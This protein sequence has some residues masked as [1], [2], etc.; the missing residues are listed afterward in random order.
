MIEV[1][2]YAINARTWSVAK[3]IKRLVNDGRKLPSLKNYE[4]IADL[5]LGKGYQGYS[6]ESE[7]D[8]LPDSKV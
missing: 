3:G 2:H 6:S 1:R 4:D 7:L 8:D 5:L